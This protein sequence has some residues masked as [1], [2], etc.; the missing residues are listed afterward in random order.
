M[1]LVKRVLNVYDLAVNPHATDKDIENIQHFYID[2]NGIFKVLEKDQEIIGSYGIYQIDQ[3]TCE[4][5]KMYL[6]LKFHGLKLGKLMLDDALIEARKLGYNEM[7]LETN[8]LLSTA[9]IMYKKYGFREYNPSHF[10]DRCDVALK[11]KL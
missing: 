7:I 1:S 3:F 6:D 2:R 11:K 5:R 10:S 4:L 9:F 8:K